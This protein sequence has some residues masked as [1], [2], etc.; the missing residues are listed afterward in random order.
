MSESG[1]VPIRSAGISSRFAS[2][3]TMDRVRP[4]TW[5]FVRTWPSGVMMVPLPDASRFSS[6]PSEYV[7]A[8]TWMR[9]RLGETL[10]SAA[11]MAA[12]GPAVV[13]RHPDRWRGAPCERCEDCRQNRAI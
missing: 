1:S 6:R 2:V 7:N 4:A 10:A 9:T 12:P 5:W 11:S 3:Q 13:S 8:T